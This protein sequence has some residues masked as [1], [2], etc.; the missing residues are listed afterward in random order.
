MSG[1]V[2]NREVST[3][4]NREE[5]GRVRYDF[6]GVELRLSRPERAS[7]RSEVNT[8]NYL[9]PKISEKVRLAPFDPVFHVSC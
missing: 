6:G 2:K 3:R 4:F 1:T 7:S 9:L 8:E 5:C